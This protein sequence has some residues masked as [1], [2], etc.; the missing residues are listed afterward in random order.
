MGSSPKAKDPPP[1]KQVLGS[2]LLALATHVR[3]DDDKKARLVE[4]QALADWVDAKANEKTA[5]DRDILVTRDFNIPSE[6]SRS[7]RPSRP[8]VSGSPTGS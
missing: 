7:S 8:R 4:L 3:W 2:R 1:V 5:D 6:A